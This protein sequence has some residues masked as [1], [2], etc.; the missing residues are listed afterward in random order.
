M[1]VTT[2]TLI[3]TIVFAGSFAFCCLHH[4]ASPNWRGRFFGPFRD[5][6][7]LLECGVTPFGVMAKAMQ[8]GKFLL[9]L[10]G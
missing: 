8:K 4:A 7:R 9:F 6:K 3:A 2:G 1:T 5:L 10:A